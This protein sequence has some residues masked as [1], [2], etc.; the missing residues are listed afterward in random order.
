VL[1]TN[2]QSITEGESVTFTAVVTDPD[3]IDDVIGG[4][5][6]DGNGNYYGAFATSGQEGAYEMVVSWG[7][8]DQ[9]ASINLAMGA[10]TQRMF[11]AEFYDQGGHTTQKSVSVS[12]S[13]LA[14]AACNGKC[15]DLSQDSENCGACGQACAGGVPCY[16]SH[17]AALSSCNTSTVTTC[18]AACAAAGKT[19]ADKCGPGNVYGGVYFSATNCT[20]TAVN[21]L[22]ATSVS[23][24]PTTKC[25]CF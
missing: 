9:V 13:C 6:G 7:Q 17:C 11:V 22:C 24:A 1:G 4:T 16:K 8:I 23:A 14:I 25:C 3:G 19:C 5:L 18:N 20:G 12:L 15:M 21:A 10:T 2:V